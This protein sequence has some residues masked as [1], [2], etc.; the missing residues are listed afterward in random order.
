[1]HHDEREWQQPDKFI[2]DRFDLS[3]PWAARPDG[4][5]RNPQAFNP[6]SGGKRI[7]L[8][9]TFAEITTRLTV[10]L[11]YYHLDFDFAE[12]DQPIL[13]R[14]IGQFQAPV[15]SFKATIKNLPN[16]N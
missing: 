15:I 8:G 4:K 16:M 9:K 13:H 10:P 7:C 5:R 11:L 3:S 2:P 12:K 14:F 1:M 6:F